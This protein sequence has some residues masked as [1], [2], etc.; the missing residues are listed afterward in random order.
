MRARPME[1]YNTTSAATL[2][3]TGAAP[4]IWSKTAFSTS[5]GSTREPR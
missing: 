1:M 3:V 5:P 4:V 2:T